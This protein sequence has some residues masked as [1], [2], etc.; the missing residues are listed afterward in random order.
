MLSLQ[1][2]FTKEVIILKEFI[3]QQCGNIFNSTANRASFCPDCRK[4]RQNER[5]KAYRH[6]IEKGLMTRTIG[7]KEICPECGQ[8]YILKSGS[9]KVCEN[10]RK[11]HNSQKKIKPNNE[12]KARNYDTCIFYLKKGEKEKVQDY[13]LKHNLSFNELVNRS[14]KLYMEQNK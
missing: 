10:C 7:E 6:K 12:Y 5:S 13:A 11:S 8:P 9:Q 4:I 14:I 2:Y 1:A 3:C